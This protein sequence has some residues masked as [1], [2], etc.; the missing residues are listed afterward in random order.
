MI[1]GQKTG[2]KVCKYTM[3]TENQLFMQYFKFSHQHKENTILI[4]CEDEKFL[5]HLAFII[6]FSHMKSCKLTLSD[7]ADLK[8][9]ADHIESS[10]S[11]ALL[12][13]NIFQNTHLKRTCLS[14]LKEQLCFDNCLHL[15]QIFKNSHEHQA[16]TLTKDFIMC[17][18]VFLPSSSFAA[19][20]EE[21]LTSLIQSERLNVTS[22]IQ[23][24]D[25]IEAWLQSNGIKQMILKKLLSSFVRYNYKLDQTTKR[26]IDCLRDSLSIS[27]RKAPRTNKTILPGVVQD[28]WM[29]DFCQWLTVERSDPH[30]RNFRLPHEAILL[31]EEGSS[32]IH[33]FNSKK[34]IWHSEPGLLFLP[35]PLKRYSVCLAENRYMYVS[36]GEDLQGKV[37]QEVFLFDL[38]NPQN[39]WKKC[40]LMFEKRLNHVS[41]YDDAAKG[42]IVVGGNNR[43]EVL[44]SVEVLYMDEERGSCWRNLPTL[45][46]ARAG[47]C[48]AILGRKLYMCGGCT[49]TCAVTSSV[50]VLNLDVPLTWTLVKPMTQERYLSSCIAIDGYLFVLG[51]SSSVERYNS[52]TDNWDLMPSMSESRPFTSCLFQGEIWC[53]GGGGKIQSWK[54]FLG[55]QPVSSME[56]W[57][58]QLFQPFPMSV[59]QCMSIK[60]LDLIENLL[61]EKSRTVHSQED[62]FS[63]TRMTELKRRNGYWHLVI[64]NP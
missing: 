4:S 22:E 42:L 14:L 23:V 19:I 15:L 53:L 45:Q 13:A 50:E 10:L 24:M 1:N 52:L 9:N 48:G 51:G 46:I 64:Q 3:G 47:A 41:V 20:D 62:L 49:T 61:G 28:R 39:G 8:I 7:S 35:K 43:R 32:A 31:L 25:A 5:N 18:F 59:H 16:F 11:N 6:H 55:D 27:A 58:P 54:P 44:G 17:N 2:L 12:V 34:R 57:V 29:S 38:K 63:P 37:W 26:R 60:G 30:M 33:V 21:L 36:G 40:P 56:S